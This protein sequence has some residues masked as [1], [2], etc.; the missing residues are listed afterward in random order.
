[1]DIATRPT[2]IVE[3]VPAN[4]PDTIGACDTAGTGMGRVN[5]FVDDKGEMVP[6]LWRKPFSVP[7]RRRLVTFKNPTGDNTKSDLEA[8]AY[9]AHNDV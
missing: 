9:V 7:I 1:M 3:L 2:R 4:I 5:F 6:L 8:T